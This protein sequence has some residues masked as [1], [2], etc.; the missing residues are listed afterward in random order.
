MVHGGRGARAQLMIAEWTKLVS[1]E[2]TLMRLV[3]ADV[4][5]EAAID[6]WR[7][8]PSE[9]YPDPRPDEIVIFKDFYWRR[10]ENPCHS[11]LRKL[12]DYYKVSICNLHPNSI[13]VVSIFITLYE[14]YLG[15]QP[16]HNL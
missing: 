8:S 11:F 10:F 12:C 15:I 2:A 9:N 16:H 14:S 3:T 7:I 4:L 5:A 13:L 6:G 1:T